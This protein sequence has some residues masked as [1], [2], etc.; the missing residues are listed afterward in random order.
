MS[1][2]LQE[3][4]YHEPGTRPPP[5]WRLVV[6]EAAEGA[7]RA[8]VGDALGRVVAMLGDLRRGKVRDLAGRP[9]A[10]SR[11]G[12][13]QFAGLDVLVGYGR[14]L[15][16]EAAHKPRLARAERPAYLA[17]LVRDG[18]FPALPWA[19][20]PSAAGEGD[21]A[22]Q[23]T[24][25]RAAAVNC[26]A[27]E[28]WKLIADEDLPLTVA[29]SFEG[30]GRQDGRG[31]LDFHDG[32]S[33]LPSSQRPQALRAGGDPA[34]MAGGTYM[35]YL[36]LAI[37]LSAWRSL[38]R[39]DQELLVGRNKL[40]GAALA[41]TRRGPDG[42]VVPVTARASARRVRGRRP[43]EWIDP[44]QTTDPLLE[45]S[46]VHR[47]NQSRASPDAPGALR[48]FRQG[49]DFL[50]GIGPAGPR[51]GLN[52]VSFQSDLSV[53]QH[54]LHLPGWLGDVNFGGPAA[55][56]RGEPKPLGFIGL[57]AGGLYAVPP[58]EEPFPGAA[59]LFGQR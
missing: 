59:A 27:V 25:D 36:R 53:V 23:L 29:A 35:A 10:E 2:R 1:P 48:M 56:G 49:Y 28:V 21:V 24:A 9:P 14:R 51:L 52:F 40:S 38:S 20:G 34:W 4:I 57:L 7:R 41:A 18:A 42:R 19:D 33:N 55:P 44:P 5:C 13:E 12:A 17:Y 32:V 3:G 54:V 58:R 31:W 16:D 8:A 43:P 47:A 22:L 15:F 39:A 45:A 30:F 26:A 46:H 6:L 37:D 11:V 50:A